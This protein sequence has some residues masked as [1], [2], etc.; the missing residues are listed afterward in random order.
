[1]LKLANSAVRYV[2][3]AEGRLS[4]ITIDTERVLGPLQK[5][6]QVLSQGG[7]NLRGFMNGAED[8]LKVLGLRYIRVDHIYD[9]FEVVS[10]EG[11]KVVYSW[12][13][14][15][16][17]VNQITGVGAKPFF[18]L[19]YMPPSIASGGDIFSE[20]SDW[21]EW[22]ELVQKTIEH[23][24]GDLGIEDVYYEVWNEPDLFGK[25]KIGGKKDYRTLYSFAVQGASSAKNVK[26]FKIGGTATTEL[27]KD[28][29]D[30]FFSYVLQNR[31]RLDFFS[32][33]RYDLDLQKYAD[34]V[35]STEAWIDRYPFFIQT[36]RIVSEIGPNSE[37]GRENDTKVGAAHLV[38]VAREF[39][40]KV[41]Y[42][43]NFAITG[44]WGII[45]KPRYEAIS[46]LSKLGDYRLP[47]SGEG[48]WVRA[49][50][51]K[52]GEKYQAVL[53]NYDAKNV[54]NEVVPVTFL[55]L[56]N[57]NYRFSIEMLGG[58]KQTSSVATSGA[59]WQTSIPMPPNSVAFLEMESEQ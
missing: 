43:F 13:K 58:A 9:E 2:V 1:M 35:K 39:M 12:S 42:G 7:D 32:W 4:A 17:L 28:W 21:N 33:H 24:S 18:S 49:I 50:A 11:G 48:T 47:V 3:G 53:V 10:R 51:A 8:K 6:W 38:A 22:S 46:Y 19:S 23:Y 20:P 36:E 44:N 37:M 29:M 52:S 16:S 26:P 34:D 15:D 5:N 56:K 54:H 31:L 59:I 57:T 41:K 30:G 40:P 55:N 27:Y 45:N 14:L 25:W